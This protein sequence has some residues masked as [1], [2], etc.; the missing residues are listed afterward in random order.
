MYVPELAG[1]MAAAED[2]LRMETEL[3][4]ADRELVIL[5]TAREVGA[6]YAWARH[7]R[8][9]AQDGTR[10]EAVEI[11]RAHGSLDGL[12]SREQMLVDV[13][14]TLIRTRALPDE[15]Y[16]R[17]EAE[18]GRK[19]LVETVALIGHYNGIGFL[20]NAFEVP[21]PADMPNF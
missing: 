10:P 11:L 18:L 21:P 17:A 2:Y 1:R 4:G 19:Q 16:S 20:L 14:H 13:V 5:A 6:R 15:L 3:P 7:E 9:A 12:T 8:R